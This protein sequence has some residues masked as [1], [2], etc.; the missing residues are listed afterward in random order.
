MIVLSIVTMN[1]RSRFFFIV[2]NFIRS[3]LRNS[4]RSFLNNKKRILRPRIRMDT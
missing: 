1:K 3:K 4:A 2:L